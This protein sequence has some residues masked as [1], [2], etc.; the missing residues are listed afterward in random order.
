MLLAT[1]TNVEFHWWSLSSIWARM[2]SVRVSGMIVSNERFVGDLSEW[3]SQAEWRLVSSWGCSR[4]LLGGITPS[5]KPQDGVFRKGH[6]KLHRHFG[7][8]QSAGFSVNCP[9]KQGSYNAHRDLLFLFPPVC[10]FLNTL[11]CHHSGFAVGSRCFLSTHD[12]SELSTWLFFVLF[13]TFKA[14]NS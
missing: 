10:L 12:A 14:L 1:Q 5:A 4:H 6:Q 11:C 2:R 3:R 9:F 8:R 13:I 7:K